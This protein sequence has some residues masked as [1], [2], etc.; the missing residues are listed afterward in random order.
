MSGGAAAGSIRIL[1]GRD[2]VVRTPRER[3]QKEEEE[4]EVYE[5]KVNL[6]ELE[7]AGNASFP[8]F[9]EEKY[10]LFASFNWH[11]PQTFGRTFF[12]PPSHVLVS[13]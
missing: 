9:R 11:V 2:S 1:F 13:A 8:S 7:G 10:S 4:E 6:W 5:R 3:Y 12:F